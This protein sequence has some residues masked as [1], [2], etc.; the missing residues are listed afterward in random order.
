MMLD[1]SS[2]ESTVIFRNISNY[3]WLFNYEK[4]ISNIHILLLSLR[5]PRNPLYIH[6]NHIIS[7]SIIILISA[8]MDN[9]NR[10]F[11]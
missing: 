6:E 8:I 5:A 2:S 4:L 1:V 7:I 11:T 9:T 10:N 3:L